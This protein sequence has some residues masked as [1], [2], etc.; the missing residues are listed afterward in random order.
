MERIARPVPK[1][2]YALEFDLTTK[3]CQECEVQA[4]CFEALGIRK[5]RVTL[6]KVV[7]KLVPA[8]YGLDDMDMGEDPELPH[9]ERTYALCYMAI[10]G[11]QPKDRVGKHQSL[12]IKRFREAQTS[13]RLFMLAN[14]VGYQQRQKTIATRLR[15]EE[16]QLFTASLLTYPSAIKRLEMY[17]EMCRKNFGTFD[18]GALDTLTEGGY[19]ENDVERRLLQSEII[20]AKALIGYKLFNGGH[21]WE[22]VY[23][24]EELALDPYWLATEDSY[25]EHVLVPYLNGD[26]GSKTQANHRY[27]VT[28]VISQMKKKR[29]WAV[30]IF[31]ARERIMPKA[32]SAVLHFWGFEAEDFEIEPEPITKAMTFWVYVGRAIQHVQCIRYAEGERS[33]YKA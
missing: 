6:D 15:C 24:N 16:K 9:I 22:Y 29:D 5:H 27:G 23:K 1:P 19:A 11:C 13:L 31:Q 12:I 26:K 28:Q 7:F 17:R 20:A 30:A 10:F 4:S 14:M 18:L 33:I 2:C 32:I 3:I 8:S 25:R 21:G